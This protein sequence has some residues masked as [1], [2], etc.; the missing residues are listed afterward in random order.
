MRCAPGFSGFVAMINAFVLFTMGVLIM[1]SPCPPSAVLARYKEPG[2][3]GDGLPEQ[4]KSPETRSSSNKN[5]PNEE[6]PSDR[7]IVP[8]LGEH[9]TGVDIRV[10]KVAGGVKVT[11]RVTH[12]D[13]KKTVSSYTR[14]TPNN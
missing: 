5:K 14:K 7:L 9:D 11:Q 13:G 3:G 2:A 12:A 10:E 1:L 8:E 6:Y 4:P